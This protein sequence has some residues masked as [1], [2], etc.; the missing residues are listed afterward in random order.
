MIPQ[1]HQ[2]QEQP[3]LAVERYGV[4]FH[5]VDTSSAPQ[6]RIHSSPEFSSFERDLVSY[7][8][9]DDPP[10]G[11]SLIDAPDAARHLEI[12]YPALLTYVS[13][14]LEIRLACADAD[15]A[16]GRRRSVA[17]RAAQTHFR[18]GLSVFHL[19]LSPE[20]GQDSA[21]NEYDLVKLIKLWE[22][23]E[24]VGIDSSHRIDRRVTFLSKGG[25]LLT[26]EDL[27][28]RVF[29]LRD[30]HARRPRLGTIQIITGESRGAPGAVDWGTVWSGIR[31]LKGGGQGDVAPDEVHDRAVKG[32]AGIMQG[33]LDFERVGLSE[34][35]D[36]FASVQVSDGLLIAVHKGTLVSMAESDRAFEAAPFVGISPY[37]LAPA[38]VLAHNEECLRIASNAAETDSRT[39]KT[40]D[41]AR[42][43]MHQ[44]LDRD[45]LP[46]IFHYPTERTI[47]TVGEESRGLRD[48]QQALR[49]KLSEIRSELQAIT[50]R[51]RRAAED[52]ISG[53]LL[54]LSGIT[55]KDMIP[56]S[57]VLPALA[58]GALAYVYWRLRT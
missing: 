13:E 46:N 11:T 5:F 3:V 58:C 17:L 12:Q 1:G 20:A 47:Y 26:I 55:L 8:Y 52:V 51:R 16:R 14:G 19:V 30:P 23:G 10:F 22:G 42:R 28:G 54:V 9:R 49:S 35:S 33:L 6:D 50:E 31:A 41:R 4:A 2:I 25:D 40:L 37:F 18:S 29:G 56:L 57:I 7:A 15:P 39:L 45:W 48:Q 43:V 34:L 32:V 38:A 27:A 44:G 36:V 24:G 21:L 53:L